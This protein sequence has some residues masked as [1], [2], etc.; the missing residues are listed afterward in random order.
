VQLV[1]LGT[2]CR[3]AYFRDGMR[4]ATPELSAEIDRVSRAFDG[5]FFGRYDVRSASIDDFRRGRFKVLE[6]NGVTS[7]VTSIYDPARSALAAY[8]VLFEQWRLA[9]EIGAQNRARGADASGVLH[10]ARLAAGYRSTAAA[11][12][13]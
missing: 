5:F 12:V 8:R 3:G 11:H 1:E 6:L 9:Y 4:L 7:E 10:L 13:D 2:H